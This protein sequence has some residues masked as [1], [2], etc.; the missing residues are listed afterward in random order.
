M[1]RPGA[2]WTWFALRLAVLGGLVLV[3]LGL[4]ADPPKAASDE[5]WRLDRLD[6]EAVGAVLLV[7]LILGVLLLVWGLADRRGGGALPRR[8]SRWAG[9]LFLLVALALG[10]LFEV[11]GPERGAPEI[12]LAT[13][14]P[15]PAPP[16]GAGTADPDG[17]SALLVVSLLLA[18]VL[19]AAW[20]TSRRAAPD[21]EDPD[22][23]PTDALGQGLAAAAASLRETAGD[24]PRGR[25][26]AAYAAF[27][28]ALEAAG[29]RRTPSGTPA[30][31]LDDAV[32]HGAPQRPATAL[33]DLFTTARYADRR[34]TLA[35][36]TAAERAL[37]ELL[38]AR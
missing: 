20:A 28:A 11:Y 18:V 5:P 7:A 15:T 38:A 19:A 3:A 35:D 16:P 8:R 30:R 29:V 32:R 26:I 1:T 10:V 34:V 23:V 31:L 22:E 37:D 2:G 13:D 6:D 33:T 9:V 27:E 21:L 24:E 4:S 36:V 12:D 17:G 14:D 25:I